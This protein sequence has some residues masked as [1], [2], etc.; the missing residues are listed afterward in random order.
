[1]GII[2][3]ELITKKNIFLSEGS[4]KDQSLL[5][6]MQEKL[7]FIEDEWPEFKSVTR[8]Y[9]NTQLK[10]QKQDNFK[11]SLKQY[12][13]NLH[14]RYSYLNLFVNWP[15][16][17]LSAMLQFFIGAYFPENKFVELLCSLSFR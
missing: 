16:S 15:Y 6:Q 9:F 5:E 10:F 12:L 4:N 11:R 2:M 13:L 8:D 1:M 17:F 7:G 14:K 3:I